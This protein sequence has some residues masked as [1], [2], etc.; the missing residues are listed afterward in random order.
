[1]TKALR[2]QGLTISFDWKCICMVIAD[3]VDKACP[4]LYT[5]SD[6]GAKYLYNYLNGIGQSGWFDTVMQQYLPLKFAIAMEEIYKAVNT[7]KDY[8]E[9]YKSICSEMKFRMDRMPTDMNCGHTFNS[10]ERSMKEYLFKSDFEK[11]VLFEVKSIIVPMSVA[12]ELC[13]T[14]RASV[15]NSFAR[16]AQGKSANAGGCGCTSA[17]ACMVLL[18]AMI[19]CMIAL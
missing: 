7:K 9:V 14:T 10:L 15:N 16:I 18:A 8:E 2:M 12:K 6:D 4:V 3:F 1:M 19:V 5:T 13:K 11:A 17:I